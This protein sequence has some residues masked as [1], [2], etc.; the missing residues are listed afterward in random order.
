VVT[1]SLSNAPPHC[2]QVRMKQRLG[3]FW[4]EW[5]FHAVMVVA[6]LAP[7]VAMS[8]DRE[9]YFKPRFDRFGLSLP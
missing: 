2:V 5:I 1:P 6:V 4:H 3:V 9:H 8:F 7:L